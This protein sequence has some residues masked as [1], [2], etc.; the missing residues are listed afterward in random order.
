[1]AVNCLANPDTVAALKAQFQP[2]VMHNAGVRQRVYSSFDGRILGT[3]RTNG[4]LTWIDYTVISWDSM[5]QFGPTQLDAAIKWLLKEAK[6]RAQYFKTMR[7]KQ[8]LLETKV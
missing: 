4:S 5:K 6:D 3:L 1:M 2:L 8:K 7:A